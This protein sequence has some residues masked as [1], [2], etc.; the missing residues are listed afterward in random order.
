MVRY[1]PNEIEPRWQ[2]YWEANQTFATPDLSKAGDDVAKRYVLDM[3]PYPSGDGLHVG[4]PEGYT[5]TDIVSRFAR[6]R[7]ECVLHPMGFDAF[8][9]PAEEHAIRTGEHPRVQTQRNIDNFTRQLKM[10]GFSYDWNRVLATTDEGYFRWTQWIFLVLFDTWFDSEAQVGRPIAE[11]PIPAEVQAQGER[12]IEL[13]RD[14]RRLAYQD[15][16][17]VNWCAKLGT[18]LANEEV[19][20]GKS[21]VGGHPVKRIPLRQWMLRITDYSER[22]LDGLEELQ[23]PAGIKKLQYDWI[24]RSSGAE[25]DFYLQPGVPS[26]AASSESDEGAARGPFVAWKRERA[27]SGFPSEAGSDALRVYTTR[28]DTLFGA[29]YMV[30]S[31]EHPLIDRL[32]TPD[33]KA[34]VDT[35]REQ[36]SFKSDR[37]RTEGDLEKTGVFTGSHAINPADGRSIPV[38]VADYVLAGYG[39]G[40]IMAVPAHDARDFEFAVAFDLPVIPVVDPPNDHPQHD[41]ILAGQ[42]C[43][44]AEGIAIHSGDYDGQTT[45]EVKAK[46]T[47]SLAE[48]GLACP[49]VNYKLRDWLFSRQRFWGEPFPILHELDAD[50]N[51]TGIKRGVPEDQLPVTLPELEDFKPHGRPEPPLAK[52]DDDWLIVELDGKRYRRETNTMPQWA[53]SCWY[54]LRYIDPHNTQSLIDPELEKTWMPVD[55]YV[56]GAEHAVLHLLYSRFWHKVL[57]D[58]GFVTCPEPFQRLVNQGM[59][60]GEVEFTGYVDSDKQPVSTQQVRRDAEG[61]RI[62]KDGR[63]L[64][65]VRLAEEDVQKKGEGFV[66]KSDPSI[67][68]DSRAFKMSKTRGNVV[69]PDGVVRDYGAD[70]LRL[71]EMFMGPLEATKPWVMNGVGGVR[72]FLDRVWRLV[73]DEKSDELRLCDAVVDTDCD[74]EQ[75]RVLHQTIRKV[76][77]DTEAMSFNTAIAKMM[78]FSNH[79]TRCEQRPRHALE[80][81]LVL[82]N[83]YAPHLSEELWRLLGHDESIALQPW[84]QWDEAALVQSSIEI[85]VQVNGKVKAKINVSPDATQDQM[86]EAALASKSVA[87]SIGDKK[88]V[89]KIAVPGRMVNLVVK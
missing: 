26:D 40:A 76:T 41:E 68:V 89:K 37:E 72:G 61:N 1:N 67:K 8:G 23:W 18:V 55:L 59:I 38:W 86:I 2:S 19:V 66:L 63:Q 28:P 73:V 58:R 43:Y 60:L 78:E 74:E 25:V 87:G 47:A 6:S 15:D 51:P 54:Y 34:E 80:T 14:S 88:V 50:G 39:T 64:E 84:P 79:F 83:P 77:E 9:L 75:L 17:L 62:S 36:A 29:T 10:L 22:L 82:L 53:G 44:V 3:F 71:Y 13:Y 69:N 11:L 32:V 27:A 48:Q 46:L 42:A 20:D 35:Y 57:Y 49:A 24:G 30:V 12:A 5:A 65:T 31:P 45:D 70:S 56:G 33:R 85:P 81:F 7:G 4:H 52:A 21:E 16:A